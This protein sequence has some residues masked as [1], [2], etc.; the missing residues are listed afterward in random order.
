MAFR[1]PAKRPRMPSNSGSESNSLMAE[2]ASSVAGL[3]QGLRPPTKNHRSQPSIRRF[4]LPRANQRTSSVTSTVRFDS[5]PLDLPSQ[6]VGQHGRENGPER[7]ADIDEREEDDFLNET[8]MALD[9]RD[10]GTVGCAFYV[11]REEK[12]HMLEDVRMGDLEVIQ[13]R[14]RSLA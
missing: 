14:E 13:S 1:A 2:E 7:D 4:A 6:T 11:A 3:S 10:R 5:Q 8:I 9:L 12:L